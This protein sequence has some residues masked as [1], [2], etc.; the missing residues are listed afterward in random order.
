M[1]ADNTPENYLLHQTPR[2]C[3]ADLIAFVPLAGYA[4]CLYQ[5]LG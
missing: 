5:G 4:W 3:A 1:A 2:T